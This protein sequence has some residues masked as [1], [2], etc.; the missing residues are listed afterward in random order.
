M[1]RRPFARRWV[2][3]NAW[4]SDPLIALEIGAELEA[5][6]DRRYWET[7]EHQTTVAAV[8]MPTIDNRPSDR[9]A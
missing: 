2:R 1:K 5:I 8:D 9:A 3:D 4:T 6:V 7:T